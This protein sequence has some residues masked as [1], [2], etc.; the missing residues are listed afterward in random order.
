MNVRPCS[1]IEHMDPCT[2]TLYDLVDQLRLNAG[3]D[4]E[5]AQRVALVCCHLVATKADAIAAIQAA[6][7]VEDQPGLKTHLRTYQQ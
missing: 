2:P 7:R 5:F 4:V 1:Y 3:T 6:F